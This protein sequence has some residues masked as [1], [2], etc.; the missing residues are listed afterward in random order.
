MKD[1]THPKK[2]AA[3][4]SGGCRSVVR[5][6]RLAGETSP[7]L[8]QHAH[9]PVDWYPWGP[10][11]LEKAKN[12]DK[13]IF[14]SI[15]YSACHWCHVME[16]E[17]F[18]H[19][20]IAALMNELFVNIKVDREERPDL[21]SI[22]MTAVQMMTGSGGWPLSVFLTPD[23]KPFYGGTYFPPVDGYGRPSFP[24]V[25]QG[26]AGAY[27]EKRS[28][29]A[30]VSD[31]IT[32]R[33]RDF[34]QRKAVPE[35]LS[36]EILAQGTEFLSSSFDAVWGGFG[37]APKF[38]P[39]LNLSFLL[40]EYHKTGNSK[41]LTMVETTLERMA[42]GGMYDQVGGGFH[43]YSTDERWLV[44][45]FEKM[46]Y[47]NAL[48][49]RVYIEAWQ[50][51]GK[52]LY[53]RIAEETFAWVRREMLDEAGGFFSSLDADSEGDEGVFHLW[54]PEEVRRV[55]GDRTGEIICAC[56]DITSAGNFE[57]RNIPNQHGGEERLRIVAEKYDLT[58]AAWEALVAEARQKL[59]TER[60]KR[61]YPH[62]DDKVLTSWNGL[63]ISA[64]A[65]GAAVLGNADYLLAAQRAASFLLET[66]RTPEG[67]LLAAYRKGKVHLPA[68]LDDYVFLIEGLLDLYQADFNPQW[69]EEGEKLNRLVLAHFAA[70]DGGGFFF[71]PDDHERLLARTREVG[72]GATPSGM[73]T[74][75]RN[76]V[77]MAS[78]LDKEEYRSL[79]GQC[80][81]H[82]AGEVKHYP[83]Q[84]PSL[85]YA[86]DLLWQ[87][88]TEIVVAEGEDR[89][90][91][92]KVLLELRSRY[93]PYAQLALTPFEEEA[94]E[95]VLERIPLTRGKTPLPG[96]TAVY[97]CRGGT[98]LAP[99]NSLGDLQDS[100][101]RCHRLI[102]LP[103]FLA[104]SSHLL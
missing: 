48:L 63:M 80:L 95:E 24:A 87:M 81:R 5:E 70:P 103:C 54:T 9:N 19:P 83:P 31:D 42:L 12:E 52:P 27:R 36:P 3:E 10:E 93:L 90:E 33:I 16:R 79:A 15:G 49:V 45:H 72:D 96:K 14:L 4:S 44:P 71:T 47:D 43:R 35:E 59:L 57:G 26:T 82:F 38:P 94:R 34:S 7:Y 76:L 88:P 65:R 11:A 1:N 92:E 77:R 89:V 104:N 85:L 99:L 6:N 98:C 28:E 101:R 13:P 75:L 58:E 86:A 30:R 73:G 37:R 8:L 2:P 40:R 102:T 84:Y 60:M 32:S 20:S 62:L 66:C 50:L 64:L 53:R 21:D 51:T 56:F 46:L 74:H 61:P 67:R 22:Y 91:N 97:I 55:L 78:Y 68:Y 41:L 17:C 100:L 23:L 69:L 29:V 18:E 39:S 25:L